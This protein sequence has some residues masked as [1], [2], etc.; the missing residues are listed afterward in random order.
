MKEW[1]FSNGIE[2]Y[3]KGYNGNLHCLEVYNGDEYLGTIYPRDIEDMQQCF[4]ILDSGKDPISDGWEDGLG[5][6]C[7]LDGWGE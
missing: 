3:E 6:D 2:V 4:E 5:N 7:T 1:T